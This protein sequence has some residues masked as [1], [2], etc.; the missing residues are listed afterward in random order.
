MPGPRRANRCT[1]RSCRRSVEQHQPHLTH[2]VCVQACCLL[3]SAGIVRHLR[4]SRIFTDMDSYLQLGSLIV[5]AI[6]G[7]LFFPKRRPKHRP[8]VPTAPVPGSTA[9]PAPSPIV[10]TRWDMPPAL[11]SFRRVEAF[12][13]D[14]AP[15]QTLRAQMQ[16]IPRPPR[17]LHQLLAPGFLDHATAAQ[18]SELILAEPQV[19]AK[20]LATANS[21]FYG[22]SRPVNSVDNAIAVLGINTVHGICLQYMV[23]EALRPRDPQLQPIFERWW[24]ASAIASQLCVRLGQRVGAPEMG[25][26]VTQV[27]LSFLGHMVALSLLP[28]Q[29]TLHNA[30]LDFLERT[31]REQEQL[32][33]CAGELGCLMMSEWGMPATVVEDVRAIDRILTSPPKQHDDQRGLR[34]ALGYYC[35]RVGEKLASGEWVDLEPAIP[36]AL[37]GPE[38]FHLQTHFMI[39]PRMMQLAQDFRDPAFVTEV[40]NMVHGVRSA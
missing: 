33:L 17:G 7:F 21:P 30:Q 39:R 25:A 4:P 35:A 38:F 40:A 31:R 27:V 22:L 11:A 13:L 34:F 8:A 23:A 9:V 2:S 6:L 1:S 29:D 28:P 3:Y 32:G 10:P 24:H 20:L 5:V 19:A 15:L 16:Q 26:M 18:L 36:E 12:E 37:Q 14:D